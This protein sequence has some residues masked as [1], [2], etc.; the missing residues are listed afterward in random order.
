MLN[1]LLVPCNMQQLNWLIITIS[2][3][4]AYCYISMVQDDR[5]VQ[6]TVLLTMVE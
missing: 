2:Y 4:L 1:V 5:L 3:I 6:S